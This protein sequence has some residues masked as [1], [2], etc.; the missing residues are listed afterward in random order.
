MERQEILAIHTKNKGRY[1]YRRITCIMRQKGYVIN[2]KTVQKLMKELHI[3]GKYAKKKFKINKEEQGDIKE[4]ILNR[5]FVSSR[6][7]EKLTTDV[8]ELKVKNRRMYLSSVI[9]IYNG[10]IVSYSCSE[11]PNAE[12]VKDMLDKLWKRDIPEGAMLHS[13][14]GSIYTSKGYQ[15]ILREHGIKQ[16]MSRR[17]NCYDNSKIE[18]FFG[19]L[20]REMYNGEEYNNAEE[21]KEA[22]D[23]YIEYYNNERIS[24]KL[25]GLSPVQYRT[26]YEKS[27][28]KSN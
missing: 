5:E 11:T 22:V 26:Q 27:E 14:Q 25:K 3:Q 2:H 9:D 13:D 8:T 1:G 17:G 10:E 20:K 19:T 18:N 7:K 15:R 4:N 28:I 16:S 6:P 23:R 21:L 12:L 24:L